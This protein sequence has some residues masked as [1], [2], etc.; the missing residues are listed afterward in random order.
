MKTLIIDN[1]DSFTYNIYQYIGELG[2]NPEVIRNDQITIDQIKKGKYS[3]IIISPGPGHPKN[4]SDFH[5]CKD[6]ILE[7]QGSIPILGICL[8]LQGMCC[9]LGGGVIHAPTV[10]HGKTTT[11]KHDGSKIFHDIP[12]SFEVMRY[13]SLVADE[14]TLPS[15]FKVTCK[16]DCGIIMAIEHKKFPMYGLQF[17]PESIGT[18]YGKEMLGNFLKV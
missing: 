5:V 8:G 11:V 1:Y 6:V 7:L 9:H 14:K 16:T 17:H 3:H 18:E 10:M 4:E 15:V 13:H 12:E 2:G